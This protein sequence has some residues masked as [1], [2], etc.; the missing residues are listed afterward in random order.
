MMKSGMATLIYNYYR[1]KS[2]IDPFV[3]EVFFPFFSFSSFHSRKKK[4]KTIFFFFFFEIKAYEDG[5]PIILESIDQ[6]PFSTFGD[7]KPGEVV[8]TIFNNLFRAPIFKH[9][10]YDSDFLVVK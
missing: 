1:K 9:N 6:S 3:P 10:S 2:E 5:T 7:V 4:K 8:S